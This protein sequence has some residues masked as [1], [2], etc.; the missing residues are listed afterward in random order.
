MVSR[1]WFSINVFIPFFTY[2]PCS[3]HFFS[4]L[5]FLFTST[6]CTCNFF[7]C[8]NKSIHN[9]L[10][11]LHGTNYLTLHTYSNTDSTSTHIL[12]HLKT[13]TN[14][15]TIPHTIRQDSYV[16]LHTQNNTLTDVYIHMHA[17]TRT[18][19]HIIWACAH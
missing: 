5:S 7:Y 17:H 13:H 15:Q 16:Y 9:T 12:T 3:L 8:T 19:P 4:F 14:T 18:H 1:F 6:G 2:S 10:N 11:D